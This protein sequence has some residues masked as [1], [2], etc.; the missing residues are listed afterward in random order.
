MQREHHAE[1]RHDKEGDPP[2]EQAVKRTSEQRRKARR[3]RPGNHGQRQSPREG[4]A[5]EQ[6][7]C[8]GARQDRGG[9]S[10]ERLDDTAE[11]QRRARCRRRHKGHCPRQ[12]LQGRPA[13]AIC[14]RSGRRAVRPRAARTQRQRRS[15]STVRPSSWEETPRLAPIR[16]KAGRMMLVAS[17][18]S[19]ARPG[20]QEQDSASQPALGRRAGCDQS[21]DITASCS[22][23][24]M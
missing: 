16:G 7:T 22:R 15:C 12:R 8:D 18:P 21:A 6:V 24:G 4:L 10:P 14:G 3:S 13:P 5:V 1:C 9:A 23:P 11:D 20:E 17:A 2:A 19:A